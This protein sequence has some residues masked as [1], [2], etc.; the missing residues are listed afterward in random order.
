MDGGMQDC[1]LIENA[2]NMPSSL[3]VRTV[4]VL[5]QL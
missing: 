1:F 5:L 4:K 2:E 3:L